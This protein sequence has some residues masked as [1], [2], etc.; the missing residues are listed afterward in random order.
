MK[1][2][3]ETKKEIKFERNEI[4]KIILKSLFAITVAVT[5]LALPGVAHI[6]KLFDEGKKN[7]YKLRRAVKSLGK[8]GFIKEYKKN[9][10]IVIEIT[11]KG[12]KKVLKYNIDELKINEPKV[13]D[14]HW[15][16]IVFDIPER[17]KKGREALRLKLKELGFKRYQNSVF[18]Y[19]YECKNEI[20]FVSTY[21][22][23]NKYVKY[24]VTKEL[25]DEEKLKKYFNIK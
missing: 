6:F 4:V 1:N 22:M 23:I 19:P 14:G 10:E 24:I 9:G 15:R 21:F 25:E 8:R 3:I 11:E 13:W 7:K 16:I 2:R 12:K 17:F 18:V 5:L 20:G